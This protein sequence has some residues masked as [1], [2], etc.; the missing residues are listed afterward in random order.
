MERCADFPEPFST[1][2]RLEGTETLTST[3]G[4]WSFVSMGIEVTTVPA[5]SL[6]TI[7]GGFFCVSNVCAGKRRGKHEVKSTRRIA[8]R[9][10]DL[11]PL[12]G[13]EYAFRGNM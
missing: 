8:E 7:A 9:R 13:P 5:A 12:T 2:A 10:M 6:N 3:T 4:T 11:P 1:Y